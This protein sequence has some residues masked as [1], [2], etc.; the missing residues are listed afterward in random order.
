MILVGFKARERPRAVDA[1]RLLPFVDEFL[2]PVHA[3]FLPIEPTGIDGTSDHS[4]A[5][6]ARSSAATKSSPPG[7][8][9]TASSGR[10]WWAS[11]SAV[12]SPSRVLRA[13]LS[14]GATGIDAPGAP[15]NTA[16]I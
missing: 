1:P 3:G 13:T 7:V 2:D 5:H 4:A 10:C 16:T 12:S 8:A 6:G 15:D 14:T 9:K 11:S